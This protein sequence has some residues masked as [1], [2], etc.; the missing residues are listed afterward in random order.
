MF[1][2]L[3]LNSSILL[4]GDIFISIEFPR[5]IYFELWNSLDL[6]GLLEAVVLGVLVHMLLM[7]VAAVLKKSLR[8]YHVHST[9]KWSIVDVGI[10]NITVFFWRSLGNFRIVSKL[11]L[12]ELY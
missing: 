11:Y 2:I 1:I 3:L 12:F 6:H 10:Y 8:S 9:C 4:G 5:Y 7:G